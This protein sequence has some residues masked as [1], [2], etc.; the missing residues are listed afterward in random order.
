MMFSMSKYQNIG[1]NYGTM[2]EICYFPLQNLTCFKHKNSV[3]GQKLKFI[4]DELGN[5][6]ENVPDYNMN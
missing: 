5:E 1:L 2:F 4:S 3:Y 6:P